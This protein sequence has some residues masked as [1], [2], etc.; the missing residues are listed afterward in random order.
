MRLKNTGVQPNHS[1]CSYAQYASHPELLYLHI[2]FF[3]TSFGGVNGS[4]SEQLAISFDFKAGP[5]Y[6]F[7]ITSISRYAFILCEEFTPPKGF[8]LV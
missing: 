6:L 8:V 4:N 1:A 7:G 2:S 5:I 3:S